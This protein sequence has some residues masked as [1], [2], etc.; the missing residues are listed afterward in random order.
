MSASSLLKEKVLFWNAK[1]TKYLEEKEKSFFN[2]IIDT[3]NSYKHQEVYNIF[4]FKT[5]QTAV[6]ADSTP[7]KEFIRKMVSEQTHNMEK[8]VKSTATN[9]Y[10]IEYS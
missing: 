4:D 2:E 9:F 8:W 7:E 3:T 1:T 6:I 5:P 10:Q